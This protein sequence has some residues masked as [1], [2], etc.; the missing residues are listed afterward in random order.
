MCIRDRKKILLT[1][2]LIREGSISQIGSEC[3]RM[4]ASGGY[5]HL[6][7]QSRVAYLTRIWSSDRWITRAGGGLVSTIILDASRH[8]SAYMYM[9]AS[10]TYFPVI[11]S[12]RASVRGQP[13]NCLMRRTPFKRRHSASLYRYT[14]MRNRRALQGWRNKGGPHW[15]SGRPSGPP[16][17]RPTG[18]P[19]WP[20]LKSENK[21]RFI[22]SP[23]TAQCSS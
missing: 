16:F 15:P 13:V 7:G 14:S 9:L 22:G 18:P 19:V 21:Q 11:I 2:L 5:W 10:A 4:D 8:A 12:G 17:G 1:S 6:G 23:H 20:L 3:A